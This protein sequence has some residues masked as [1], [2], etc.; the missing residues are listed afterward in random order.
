MARI[1]SQAIGIEP[2]SDYESGCKIKDGQTV[3]GEQ[4]NGD[5]V[6]FFQ[7]LMAEAS[8]PFNG[9]P[10]NRVYGHQFI[11]ALYLAVYSKSTYPLILDPSTG[12]LKGKAKKILS[13]GSWGINDMDVSTLTKSVSHGLTSSEWKTITNIDVILRN[14]D[15]TSIF[16]I[17]TPPGGGSSMMPQGG[18]ARITS[19]LIN[20]EVLGGGFFDCGDF[21]STVMNRGYISIEYTPD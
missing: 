18:I 15:Y 20:L 14:D 19:S 9:H 3:V 17:N 7:K 2:D 4:I 12:Y 11:T 10:D 6:E 5:I 1:L 8:Q 13:I 21:S 16:P